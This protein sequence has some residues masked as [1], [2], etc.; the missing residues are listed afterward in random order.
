MKYI[1]VFIQF[2][3]H[4]SLYVEILSPYRQRLKL[5]GYSARLVPY[6]LVT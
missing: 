5:G 1:D 6:E 4:F 3:F 2:H